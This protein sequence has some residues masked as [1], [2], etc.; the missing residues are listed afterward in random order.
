MHREPEEDLE[1]VVVDMMKEVM[2]VEVHEGTE[3]SVVDLVGV[4]KDTLPMVDLV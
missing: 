2:E 3:D 4:L 1:V